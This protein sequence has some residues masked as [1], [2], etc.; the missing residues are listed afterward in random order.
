MLH[1]RGQLHCQLSRLQSVSGRRQGRPQQSARKGS[2]GTKRWRL[3]TPAAP[4]SAPASLSPEQEK[5]GPDRNHVVRGGRVVKAKATKE[6]TLSPSGAGWQTTG[7]ASP[8]VGKS[9]PGRPWAP[10]VLRQPPQPKNTD[11][12]PPQ[13][14]SQS[15]LEGIP[16]LLD[17]LP[18]SACVELTRRLLSTALS[19]QQGTLAREPSSKPLFF[20]W[21]SMAARP[22]R[23]PGKALLLACW[24][25]DGVRGR[26]LELE[27]LL[28]GTALTYASSTRPTSWR[29]GP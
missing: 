3:L 6:P 18:T 25:A 29:S 26:K 23:T 9:K 2:A 19:L 15:P 21:L 27:Q 11:S 22:R 24:N 12:S 8:A 13:P 14:Q 10:V 5:L 16:D 17:K 4:K 1:L 7:R 20:S 28:S